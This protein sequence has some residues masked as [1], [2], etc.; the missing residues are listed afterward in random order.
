MFNLSTNVFVFFKKDSVDQN[1]RYG[2][3]ERNAKSGGCNLQ[4]ADCSVQVADCTLL[5]RIS[6]KCSRNML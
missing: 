4:V 5:V 1:S 3:A 6:Q 2:F